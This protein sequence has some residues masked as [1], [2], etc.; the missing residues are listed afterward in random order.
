MRKQPR[1]GI[2]IVPAVEILHPQ[3]AQVQDDTVSLW[4][5]VIGCLARRRDLCVSIAGEY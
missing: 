4:F 3:K 2:V 5:C 1:V